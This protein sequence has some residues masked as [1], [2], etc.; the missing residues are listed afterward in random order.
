[1]AS[2]TESVGGRYEVQDV[3]FGK[4]YRWRPEGVVVECECGRRPTLTGSMTV[5]A[6]GVDHAGVVREELAHR[7]EDEAARPW[8]RH[9]PEDAGLPF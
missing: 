8:R 2:V 5:C 9:H 1:M 7:E 6:C 3:E 4:V